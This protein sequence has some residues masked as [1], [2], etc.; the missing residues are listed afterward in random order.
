MA[1]FTP[2]PHW[3]VRQGLVENIALAVGAGRGGSEGLL[4]LPGGPAHW[5]WELRGGA[6]AALSWVC[7]LRPSPCALW[8]RAPAVVTWSPGSPPSPRM[9]PAAHTPRRAG[10][11]RDAEDPGLPDAQR[12]SG[13]A[14]L[15]QCPA[16]LP[17]GRQDQGR[18]G[19]GW[20]LDGAQQ[21]G[22]HSPGDHLGGLG[23]GLGTVQTR[24]EPDGPPPSPLILTSRAVGAPLP[25]HLQ[26]DGELDT[27]PA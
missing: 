10:H 9:T 6:G 19:G 4:G 11:G 21:G 16:G 20:R 8:V 23:K 3:L 5:G 17:R 22:D 26:S 12:A 15:L 24:W 14:G 13:E 1:T 7:A 2:Q 25:S 18:H 27:G